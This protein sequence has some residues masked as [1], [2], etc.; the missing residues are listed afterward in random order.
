MRFLIT[1]LLCCAIL[2]APVATLGSGT[3]TGASNAMNP[4][5]S[6]NGLFVAET[7]RERD[8]AEVNAVRLQEAELHFTAVVDP[9]WSANIILAVLPNEDDASA[10]DIGVE[11]ANI[12]STSMPFGLGLKL[13]K[14]FLPFGK[15]APL[16]THHFPFLEAPLAV[17]TYLGAGLTETGV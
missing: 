1:V 17:S 3:L 4:A 13:G 9:F 16:H 11:E 12:E 6:V 15:H 7:S 2:S 10:C 8:D 5:F 14:F